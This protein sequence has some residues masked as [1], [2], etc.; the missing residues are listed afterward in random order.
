MLLIKDPAKAD[1]IRRFSC[2]GYGS[3]SGN[4]QKITRED[5]QDP[6]YNRHMCMGFN[7]RMSE[8]QAACALG[9]LERLEDLVGVRIRVG[10][11]FSEA[12]KEFE[13]LLPVKSFPDGERVN[14]YWGF[15]M[16]LDCEDEK[17]TV[18]T[19]TRRHC[20]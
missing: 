5:L 13:F 12:I 8:L 16:I 6:L 7:F 17:V 19:F 14:T 1:F 9:Q 18:F 3:V 10:E 4:K 2:L 11:M 15:V 20:N